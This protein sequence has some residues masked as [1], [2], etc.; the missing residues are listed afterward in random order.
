MPRIGV[1]NV[2]LLVV[3]VLMVVATAH[4]V[5]GQYRQRQRLMRGEHAFSA[6]VAAS[7]GGA[8]GPKSLVRAASG[9]DVV[10]ADRISGG[11]PA[12]RQC[13]LATRSGPYAR[14]VVGGYRRQAGHSDAPR[15]RYACFGRAVE[16][17]QCPTS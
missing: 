11:R 9:L 12:Y 3:A 2:L 13:V 17:R 8:Y 7:G 6:W 15:Y 16:L 10:C 5:S 14:R 1:A 4:Q